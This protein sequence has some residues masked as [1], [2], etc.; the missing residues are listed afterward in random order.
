METS[1]KKKREKIVKT[2]KYIQVVRWK[3]GKV[4]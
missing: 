2:A 1:L 3:H 4:K